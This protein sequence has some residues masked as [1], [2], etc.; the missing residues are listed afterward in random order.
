MYVLQISRECHIPYVWHI[1]IK[2]KNTRASLIIHR[3]LSNKSR[4]KGPTTLYHNGF[5][6]FLGLPKELTYN[7]KKIET[8][9]SIIHMTFGSTT[10]K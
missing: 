1:L 10:R 2:A 6:L 5:K 8:F 7:G 3:C 4:R 9:Q